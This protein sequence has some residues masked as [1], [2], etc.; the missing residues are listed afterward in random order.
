MASLRVQT[1]AGPTNVD[2]ADI[3]L[4]L[5]SPSEEDALTLTDVVELQAFVEKKR[6]I[7]QQIVVLRALEPVDCFAGC[8]LTFAREDDSDA[9][10]GSGAL[11]TKDEVNA[12]FREHERIE[13]EAEQ[14]DG[15]EIAR[16]RQMAKGVSRACPS[17]APGAQD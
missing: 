14:L 8:R 6:W 9:G 16:L 5:P 13:A 1:G 11:P 4:P 10:A 7:E 15:G 12:M 17:S 3:S 2:P